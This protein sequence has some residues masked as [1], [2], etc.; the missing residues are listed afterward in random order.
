[1]TQAEALLV[2]IQSRLVAGNLGASVERSRTA[3]A[4]REALPIVIVKPKEA[5]FTYL[6]TNALEYALQVDIAVH[7]R[8]DV[9][10]QVADPIVQKIHQALTDDPTLGGLCALI[11]G[12]AV[13]W[14]DADADGDAGV[15]VLTYTLHYLTDPRNLG[16]QV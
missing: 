4:D 7:V 8:G 15:T 3:A 13:T 12:P 14:E 2:A 5:P 11:I 9:P 10:D 16:R 6:A 1:M